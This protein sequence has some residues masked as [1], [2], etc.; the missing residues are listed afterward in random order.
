M[1]RVTKALFVDVAV[2]RLQGLSSE[3]SLHPQLTV[4]LA[5]AD[6]TLDAE[7]PEYHRA[8]LVT[9]PSTAPAAA[10]SS[11]GASSPSAVAGSSTMEVLAYSTGMQRSSRLLSMRSANALLF[12]P[13]GPGVVK[14]GS[15]VPA[16]LI[17]PLQFAPR[18][19]SVHPTAALLDFPSSANS[20]TCFLSAAKVS[21]S[22]E[23]TAY[24][25]Y[26]E[27]SAK[28]NSKA[29]SSEAQVLVRVG[30]LTVSD[31]VR[32]KMK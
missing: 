32:V 12:L 25:H 10:C 11:T 2:R 22:A 20:S 1:Y 18:G 24:A 29:E 26:G 3:A 30:L 4:R 23:A 17:R 8:S 16:L 5:G 19:V 9:A 31:R 28:G 27:A 7:R 21:G 14:V 15:L 13:K 6:I